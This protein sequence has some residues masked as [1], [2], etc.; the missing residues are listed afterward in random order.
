MTPEEFLAQVLPSEGYYCLAF[1]TDQGIRH[2]V[3]DDISSLVHNANVYSLQG[4]EVYFCVSTLKEPSIIKD[5]K[6]RV[7]VGDNCHQLAR[8]FWT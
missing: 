8:I 2:R 1:K 7:R 3:Y 6:Y 5:G 4:C